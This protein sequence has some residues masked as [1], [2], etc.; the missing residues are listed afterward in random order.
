MEEA[1]VAVLVDAKTEYTK[2]L[3]NIIRPH[4]YE[5]IQSIYQDAN[6]VCEENDLGI[7]S[8]FSPGRPKIRSQ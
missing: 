2:R 5:G 1:N 4:I 6:D 7:S 3:V 8:K